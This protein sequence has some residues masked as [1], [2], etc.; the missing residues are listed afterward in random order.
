MVG[1]DWIELNEPKGYRRLEDVLDDVF[2]P[3]AIAE[4]LEDEVTD[5]VKS[6]L[7]EHGYVDKD[8]RSTLYSFYAKKGRA[9]RRDCV[10]LHFFD[11]LVEFDESRTDLVCADGK[12]GNHYYGYIVLR[13]TMIATLGRSVLAPGIRV[14]AG[15]RAIQSE[16]TVN[17]LGY[18]LSVWGFPS[19]EQP[20]DIA[21]CAHV[22][23]W[24]ILRYYS[25]KY[26]HHREYLIYDMARL[27]SAFDPGGLVPSLGLTVR[28]A[29]RVFQAAGCYPLVVAKKRAKE[30]EEEEEGGGEAPEDVGFYEELLAYLESGFPLFVEMRNRL[31]AVVLVGRCWRERSIVPTRDPS[32]AWEQV[33]TLLMVDDNRLPYRS[34]PASASSS[35][36]GSP[37]YSGMDFD[38]FIVALP[39]KIH[40]PAPAVGALSDRLAV[41]LTT[42]FGIEEE[43]V[44]IRRHFMT[45]VAELRRE[46]R[47]QASQL[48]D[49][50]VGMFMRLNSAQYVWV[51]EFGSQEHWDRGT[52][53]GRAIVD[54]TASRQD[55]V[56][57]LLL[58]D[59]RLAISFD[60]SPGGRNHR[61]V[62]LRRR[63]MDSLPRLEVNLRQVV[64]HDADGGSGGR[65]ETGGGA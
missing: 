15:G 13:P 57:T 34:V 10:R 42:G 45:T 17:V 50:L 32:H 38:R 59:E 24:A 52:V 51:V 63:R 47:E 20:A 26:P 14:G 64:R 22:S 49:V 55:P 21:V 16:H 53:A 25:E 62:P 31:H 60:R 40:F 7:V 56:A 37:G 30:K 46:V 4:R 65:S 19:M 48:G 61:P 58:H 35:L 8:Y 3:R 2:E 9:Y 29:E 43:S 18:S 41:V 36:A 1:Y 27:A 44:R 23:C 12:P 33:D 54:A 28:E 39:E 6:V 5:A 11:G